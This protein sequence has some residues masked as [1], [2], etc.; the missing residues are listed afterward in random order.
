[1]T[2]G[3]AAPPTPSYDV[4]EGL[5]RADGCTI[6]CE[7][8]TST[9]LGSTYC[10]PIV[11][12]DGCGIVC[13]PYPKFQSSPYIAYALEDPHQFHHDVALFGMQVVAAMQAL[14]PGDRPE[15]MIGSG[16]SGALLLPAL[17]QYTRLP[18]AIVRKATE[19]SH[20]THTV[21]GWMARNIMFVDDMISSG[22]TFK[23]CYR[24]YVKD[25]NRAFNGTQYHG[26]RPRVMMLAIMFGKTVR[27]Y[28]EGFPEGA[29]QSPRDLKVL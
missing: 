25:Y 14:P 7:K 8:P 6:V 20:A 1:M 18:I 23:R 19:V 16:L 5:L 29:L 28:P 9:P 11:P 12:A 27:T 26:T 13:S 21:E 15:V 24:E 17:S 22:A 2:Q 3:Y 10:P 4:L